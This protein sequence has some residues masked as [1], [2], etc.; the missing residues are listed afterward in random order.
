MTF[1]V[2]SLFP[3]PVYKATIPLTDA[4]IAYAKQADISYDNKLG[5]FYSEDVDILDL[6]VYSGLKSDIMQHVKR[7]AQ[8]VLKINQ[9]LYICLSW[10]TRNPPGSQ[11]HR[12]FHRNSFLSGTLYITDASPI[13]FWSKQ[14]PIFN[15]FFDITAKEY[16]VFNSSSWTLP[17][18]KN[19]LLIWPSYFEHSVEPNEMKEDRISLAFNVFIKDSVGEKDNLTFLQL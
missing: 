19:D 5:N 12:H 2:V 17:V 6:E 11:M 9:E 4:E 14:T 8:E 16:N 13:K 18:E 15:Q 1:Q 7:Y 3:T 10:F